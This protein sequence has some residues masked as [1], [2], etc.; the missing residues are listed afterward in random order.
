MIARLLLTAI[1][2]FT[3]TLSGNVEVP[4]TLRDGELR[5]FDHVIRSKEIRNNEGESFVSFSESPNK[6]WV[7]IGYDEPFEKT[8]VWLYD[9]KTKSAPAVVR[10]KRAG[11]HFGVDWYGDAVFAIFWGGM[12]YKTS[13][14]FQ[15]GDPGVYFQINDVV[16]YDPVR[17]IYARYA[18]DKDNNHFV[19]V[20][21][22][23]HGPKTEEKYTI[24]LYVED[25]LDAG[26]SIEVQF[27]SNNITISYDSEKGPVTESHRSKIIENAK[28]QSLTK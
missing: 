6:R 1:I 16:F 28:P 20:G 25:M 22:A 12:G 4:Y 23:F 15:V 19:F 26:S 11:K 7:V 5:V 24:G 21:R 13:Q 18:L 17:D 2:A 27:G 3:P 14:L 10:A 9:R 8:Y